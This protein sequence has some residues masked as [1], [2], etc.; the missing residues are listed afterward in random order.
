MIKIFEK[1]RDISYGTIESRDPEQVYLKN[2]GTCSGKHFLFYELVSGLGFKSKHF[3][4]SHKFRQFK[5][6][7]PPRLQEILKEND[8]LDYHNFVKV[9]VNGKW[10]TI[11]VTW[12]LPL[13][14]YGFPVQENWDGKTDIELSVVP[15]E[16]WEVKNPEKFKE[17]KL[18]LMPKKEQ[19]I[20]KLFIQK[21]SEWVST[22]R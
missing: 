17:E 6:K 1:V 4:C 8:I 3:V 15:I 19:K 11:D 10:L 16:I 9:F 21:L 14:K 13:K 7:F 22:L 12:D 20:R 5:V 18:A 2:K